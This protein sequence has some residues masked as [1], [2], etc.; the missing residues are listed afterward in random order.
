ME[1]L[2]EIGLQE[3]I[4][5]REEIQVSLGQSLKVNKSPRAIRSHSGSRTDSLLENL[6]ITR[7][8]TQQRELLP[9]S[10][11]N[12]SLPHEQETISRREDIPAERLTRSRGSSLTTSGSTTF[13]DVPMREKLGRASR[14]G[15]EC[16]ST[17]SFSSNDGDEKPERISK[18]GISI[19]LET[20]A[21]PRNLLDR[22]VE[23]ISPS[24][25]VGWEVIPKVSTP[26]VIRVTSE[27]KITVNPLHEADEDITDDSDE[28][29]IHYLE[30]KLNQSQAKVQQLDNELKMTQNLLQKTQRRLG[31]R[32]KKIN[33]LE[34][35]I[36]KMSKSERAVQFAQADSDSCEESEP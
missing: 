8:Y 4:V 11:R 22:D 7:S 10:P 5:S 15:S 32:D 27:Q 25:T 34:R 1:R 18:K 14:R 19:F 9:V 2:E 31:E 24:L 29:Q 6:L 26:K 21:S 36:W 30:R 17:G 12:L 16:N 20:I 33:D 35:T 13:R 28:T 23:T 3:E